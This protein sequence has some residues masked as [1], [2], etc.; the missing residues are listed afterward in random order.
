M[1]KNI[2]YVHFILP[3]FR[4]SGRAQQGRLQLCSTMVLHLGQ[5]EQLERARM[6]RWGYVTGSGLF[7]P[8]S[9]G[10]GQASGCG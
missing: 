10:R 3:W 8:V 6:T 5:V 1:R 2:G 9:F 7:C 4:K